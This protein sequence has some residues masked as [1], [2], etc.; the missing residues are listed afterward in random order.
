MSTAPI[1][2]DRSV[3]L[4]AIWTTFTLSLRSLLS[5]KRL[6]LLILLFLLPVVVV[7][8]FRYLGVPRLRLDEEVVTARF[9]A[10]EF[11]AVLI[12]TANVLAPLTM[13]LFASGMI[14]DEQENQTLTYLMVRPIP[15]W[16]VY[17]A[18][19]L[20][21]ILVAWFLTMLGVAFTLIALWA[22]S[23]RE[24]AADVAERLLWLMPA[25]ALLLAANGAVFACISVL[26]RR[27]L[28][29]GVVY[30]ALF[31][32]FLANFPFVLR[33]FT[34]LH[35]FQCIVLNLLGGTYKH[36]DTTPK[37]DEIIRWS[38]AREVVP[39]TQECVITLLAVFVIAA[40]AGMWLFTIREFRM[41]TPETGS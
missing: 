28:I 13:L 17:L 41:K 12:M 4:G 25:F 33:K 14:R 23:G 29:I 22:G 11:R 6:M 35:Y 16:A 26:F 31:E 21:S 9:M 19:L 38:L 36:Y 39:D 8:V 3:P 32:G 34:N 18:K 20:A 27:A 2:L 10:T 7:L 30:I 1:T 5:L 24:P 37:K 40:L 15:R